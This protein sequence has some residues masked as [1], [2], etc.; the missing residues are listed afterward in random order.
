V[1]IAVSGASLLALWLYVRLGNR[2][3]RSLRGSIVQV[4]LALG[5]LAVAPLVM[6]ALLDA[7]RSDGRALVALLVVFLP[8][9]TYTFL[10]VLY[11]FEHLQ[12]RLF[13]R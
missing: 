2:R 9:M 7:G 11:F 4:L 1:F 12:R 13:L 5:A 6:E 10:A 8:A 3:P